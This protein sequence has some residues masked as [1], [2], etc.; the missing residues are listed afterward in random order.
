V[1]TQTLLPGLAQAAVH[2]AN[3]TEIIP[4]F[5]FTTPAMD[6]EL[7]NPMH[8]LEIVGSGMSAPV[9]EKRPTFAFHRRIRDDPAFAVEL[10]SSPLLQY[11][12]VMKSAGSAIHG[13]VREWSEEWLAG[14]GTRAD[15][16]AR[17]KG[18]VEEVV[19]G[20][21]IWY[22][23]GGWATRGTEERGFNADFFR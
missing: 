21:V 20:N 8:R 12:A 19:W 3:Q 18:M 13:L 22:G 6:V 10:P 14:V 4:P 23:I 1:F 15:A 17:L 2:Q 11:T 7:S 9:L 5:Y 16:E